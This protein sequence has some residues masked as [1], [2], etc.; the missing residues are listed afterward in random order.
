MLKVC[1][2]P[3]P[4]V[5]LPANEEIRNTIPEMINAPQLLSSDKNSELCT[6]FIDMKL[7]TNIVTGNTS[8]LNSS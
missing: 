4:N 8:N 5:K 2:T 1:R 7:P 3:G 6:S